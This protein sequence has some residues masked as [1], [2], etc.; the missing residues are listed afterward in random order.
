MIEKVSGL[1]E[2]MRAHK[3]KIVYFDQHLARIKKSCAKFN[4]R[5]PYSFVQIKKQ[6]INAIKKSKLNDARVRLII[7][8]TGAKVDISIV[9]KRYNPPSYK[10]YKSGFRVDLVGSR[11]KEN[12]ALA[13]HK[14]TDRKLYERAFEKA[15]R[16]GFDEALILND[17]GNICEASRSNIFFVKD[18]L[19][20]T[21]NLGCGC[22][23]GITRQ[24][25]LDLAK[26]KKIKLRN[27]RFTLQDL[28][29]ADE[30]FLTNSLIGVMPLAAVR[31]EQIKKG[32]ITRY[33]MSQYACLLRK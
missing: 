21:P 29:V 1:F 19:L 30:A 25:I 22:L 26:R 33:F 14:I 2:T 4:I 32:A 31:K 6:I 9:I 7:S 12:S 24:V 10:K 5:L 28:L 20:F 15:K 23:P 17:R 13:I 8:K 16:A 27:G 11:Q 18:K 3:G